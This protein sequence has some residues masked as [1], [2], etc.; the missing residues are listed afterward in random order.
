M[1]GS[2]MAP[3]RSAEYAVSVFT[4]PQTRPAE[5]T[6]DWPNV[7]AR[8]HARLDALDDP[9]E[10]RRRRWAALHEDRPIFGLTL[11]E[12][13]ELLLLDEEFGVREDQA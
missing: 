9:A 3:K 12:Q 1:T 11:A 5:A 2:D 10:K 13:A 8:H 4:D 7:W 6:G